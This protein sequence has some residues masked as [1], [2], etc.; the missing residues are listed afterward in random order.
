MNKTIINYSTSGLGNRLRPLA[1]CYAISK[2]SDRKLIAYWDNITPNG[3]LAKWTDLFQ[4]ELETISLEELEQ[5]EDCLLLTESGHGGHGFQREYEKFGRIA[6]KNLAMKNSYRNYNSFDYIDK[7]KNIILYHNDF[8][9]AVDWKDTCEFLFNLKPVQSIQDRI[10]YFRG[11]LALD[12][13]VIGLHARGTDFGVTVEQYIPAVETIIKSYDNP[14]IFLSTE[15]LNFEQE[16][17]QRF[18]NNIVVRKKE[19]YITKHNDDVPWSDHN[20]FSI[21]TQHAQEA[22]E[23]LYLLA[24]TNLQIYHPLSSFG[25]I[26]HILSQKDNK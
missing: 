8:L 22:I 26:A 19:N 12:K 11:E 4:N 9:S 14:R 23:D 18:P 2:Q 5:L 21:T 16:F 6:L 3:C 17:L 1:S 24:S 7:N 25:K 10:N 15:D 20:N 13:N